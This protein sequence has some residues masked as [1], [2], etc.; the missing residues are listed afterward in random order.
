MFFTNNL[1]SGRTIHKRIQYVCDV[2]IYMRRSADLAMEHWGKSWGKSKRGLLRAKIF[3]E[4]FVLLTLIG[5]GG[6]EQTK[7]HLAYRSLKFA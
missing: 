2:Y 6:Y 1:I 7:S 3:G 5:N 4:F